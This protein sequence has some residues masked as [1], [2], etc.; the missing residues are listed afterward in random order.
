MRGGGFHG[1]VSEAIRRSLCDHSAET[2]RFH[3]ARRLLR[4]RVP[5]DH[6]YVAIPG[7]GNCMFAAF[8]QALEAVRGEDISPLQL[9]SMCVATIR[10]DARLSERFFDEAERRAFC[11][12]MAREGEY[13][14]ELCLQGLVSRFKIC[15]RV[16]MPAA[17]PV[18]FG[19]GEQSVFLAYNGYNHF[20][21]FLPVPCPG[22]SNEPAPVCN[23][24]CVKVEPFPLDTGSH[25]APAPDLVLLSANITSW[26]SRHT[27]FDNFPA[28]VKAFQEVRLN[29]KRAAEAIRT[30]RAGGGRLVCGG[31]V[32]AQGGVAVQTRSPT[33]SLP[34]PPDVAE[35]YEAGRALGVS[36]AIADGRRSLHVFTVYGISGAAKDPAK[37]ARSETLLASVFAW[38]A[39]YGPGP[40][41]I[42]GDFNVDPGDS[43]TCLSA[44]AAGGWHDLGAEA[45]AKPTFHA[46]R[47]KCATSSRIDAIFCNQHAR[48]L[49]SDFHFGQFDIPYHKALIVRFRLPAFNV[50]TRVLRGPK[51]LPALKLDADAVDTLAVSCFRSIQTRWQSCMERRDVDSAWHLLSCTCHRFLHA[52]GGDQTLVPSCDRGLAPVV[53]KR[54]LF[55]P[56]IGQSGFSIR[57]ARLHRLQRRI[58]EASLRHAKRGWTEP[59]LQAAIQRSFSQL[60]V[61]FVFRDL[62]RAAAQVRNEIHCEQ[63]LLERQRLSAWKLRMQQSWT[64]NKRD[65]FKWIRAHKALQAIPEAISTPHGLC[66]A[67]EELLKRVIAKWSK[68]FCKHSDADSPSW[69]AFADRYSAH[70]SYHA[71]ELP[72]LSARRLRRLACG[73]RATAPGL[74]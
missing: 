40:C 8:S 36:V 25:S 24:S 59:S 48:P 52:R 13:G 46:V 32:P 47:H 1:E 63:Q 61:G 30:V 57:M 17:P 49:V 28:A 55:P 7:D 33:T 64:G 66:A 29:A 60:C 67:P 72:P 20:D 56:R 37:F 5:A 65:V 23:T 18:V 2:Q 42:C 9:R 54:L 6:F 51:P 68:I 16:V 74:D 15:I 27:L 39:L 45:G 53:R 35:W 12:R 71:V 14:D 22:S 50:F 3:E 58:Q 4:D 19:S 21:A 43:P 31:P 73:G 41:V 34:R 26:Q 44:C 70:F 62:S 69:E 11:T 10:D 38:A